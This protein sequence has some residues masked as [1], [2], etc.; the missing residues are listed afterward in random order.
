ME[1]NNLNFF[2]INF[3]VGENNFQDKFSTGE[4]E[5][6]NLLS[7][8][9]KKYGISNTIISHFLCLSYSPKVGNDLLSLILNSLN[10]EEIFNDNVYGAMLLEHEVIYSNNSFENFLITRFK[11]GFRILRLFPKSHKYPYEKNLLKKYYKVCDYYHFPIMINLEEIDVTGDKFIDWNELSKIAESFENMPIIIDGG[12]AKA[13]QYNS[14]FSLLLQNSQSIY[15]TT[16]NLYSFNQIEDLI[17]ISS[18]KRLIF[19][20]YY[21]FNEIFVS[22]QRIVNSGLSEIDK[23]DI[24]FNNINR[25]IKDIAI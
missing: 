25:I 10:K 20:S 12:N 23:S 8:I 19:D 5:I 18:A 22:T 16:H 24:A 13:L 11:Q 4:E 9:N 2:D 7:N 3:W 1:I 14:Y 15:L 21:P 17:S 6:P